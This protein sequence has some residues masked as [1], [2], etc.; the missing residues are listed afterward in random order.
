MSTLFTPYICELS[1]IIGTKAQFHRVSSLTP[2]SQNINVPRVN[3]DIIEGKARIH[4]KQVH[5]AHIKALQTL[6]STDSQCAF[7]FEEDVVLSPNNL[8]QLPSIMR[9]LPSSWQYLNL[10]RCWSRCD[11]QIV[12]NSFIYQNDESVCRHAYAVTRSGANIIINQS[13][14]LNLPGDITICRM[15][16]QGI[17]K[18]FSS[19]P[20]YTQDRFRFKSLNK[21]FNKLTPECKG[22]DTKRI[23]NKKSICHFGRN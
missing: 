1:I 12:L 20:L 19:I 14:P 21:Q 23:H 15:I 18:G 2:T 6:L 9:G 11:R 13:L 4:R 22:N 16:S 5:A 7:I 3:Y 17:L 10:G 8:N